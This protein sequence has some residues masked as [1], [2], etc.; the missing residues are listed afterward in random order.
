[1]HGID[2]GALN[3]GHIVRKN[4]YQ[5]SLAAVMKKP[6]ILGQYLTVQILTQTINKAT[7]QTVQ[8]LLGQKPK[9]I[10]QKNRSPNPC[11][12][13]GQR[14]LTTVFG[15]YILKKALKTAAESLHRAS[16]A[17]GPCRCGRRIRSKNQ[18]QQGNEQPK[19]G[20]AKNNP[21]DG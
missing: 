16:N 4:G 7:A 8:N 19:I 1:M 21:P 6:N 2:H 12:N 9:N 3:L 14:P 17:F 11:T 5:I 18:V 10:G 13:Q 15:Q 20:Q